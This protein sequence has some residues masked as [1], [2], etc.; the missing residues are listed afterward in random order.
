MIASV[1]RK[2]ASASFFYFCVFIL[3]LLIP[4]QSL[5]YLK[6]SSKFLLKSLKLHVARY[7]VLD[8][9]NYIN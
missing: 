7:T 5:I 2:G 1:K 6:I 9:L 3:Q 4:E 8:I